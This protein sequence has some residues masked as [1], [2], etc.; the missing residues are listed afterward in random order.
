MGWKW[1][2][3]TDV[4]KTGTGHTPDRSVAEYWDG[5]I[6]WV[7]LNEIRRFDGRWCLGTHTRITPA[8]VANSS[9]VLHPRETVCFS[10]TASIGFVTLMSAP[11]TTSQDFVT[12]TCGDKLNPAYL[13]QALLVARD[14]LRASSSGS[15]HKTIYVR[16]AARFSILLPPRE[17]QDTFAARLSSVDGIRARMEANIRPL[18]DLF[19]SA[20]Q[21]AFQGEL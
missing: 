10:R 11:M 15:T 9:A 4:A 8:G 13:M 3:V 6:S 7:N 1:V 17:L 14:T 2:P 18:D 5:E 12:W 21:R 20:Q 19:A 16:D